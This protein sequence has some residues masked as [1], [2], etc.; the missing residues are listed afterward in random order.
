LQIRRLPEADWAFR[1]RIAE[2]ARLGNA[3]DAAVT[4][5]PTFDL[6]AAL[7][8]LFEEGLVVEICGEDFGPPT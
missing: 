4:L 5:D 2:G 6:V 1:S 3:V 7:S 8:S